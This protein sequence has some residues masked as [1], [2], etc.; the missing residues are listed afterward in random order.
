MSLVPRKTR[1]NRDYGILVPTV[2]RGFGLGGA[3][4]FSSLVLLR[5]GLAGE[6]LWRHARPKLHYD[7]IVIGGGDTS[8]KTVFQ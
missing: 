3:C 7:A 2:R 8:L 6:P 5:E 4:R 1:G